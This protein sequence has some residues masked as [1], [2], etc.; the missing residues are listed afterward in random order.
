MKSWSTNTTRRKTNYSLQSNFTRYNYHLKQQARSQ[1]SC[2]SI[3]RRTERNRTSRSFV[4]EYTPL[5]LWNISLA[6][7]VASVGLMSEIRVYAFPVEV[8]YL[9]PA[10]KV[11]NLLWQ[12]SAHIRNV[13]WQSLLF[14]LYVFINILKKRSK[15]I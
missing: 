12:K 11:T 5:E 7:I 1:T 2:L 14:Q 4:P 9:R 13:L 3:F 6:Q 8:Y 10:P 15:W